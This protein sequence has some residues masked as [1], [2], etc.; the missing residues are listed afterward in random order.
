MQSD[1]VEHPGPIGFNVRPSA[2]RRPPRD[3]SDDV[4]GVRVGEQCRSFL[5][6]DGGDV[7]VGLGGADLLEDRDDLLGLGLV[8]RLCRGHRAD[9]Q[10]GGEQDRNDQDR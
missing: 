8:V 4:A 1:E 3:S 10:R 2:E 6:P 5:L 7:V 9:G